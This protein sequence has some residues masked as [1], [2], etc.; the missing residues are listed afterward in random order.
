MS[1]NIGSYNSRRHR[2]RKAVCQNLQTNEVECATDG[3]Q[4]ETAQCMSRD[5]KDSST[6]PPSICNEVAKTAG[7]EVTN[8]A[9][10]SCNMGE[11]LLSEDDDT[12]DDD[13]ITAQIAQINSRRMVVDYSSDDDSLDEGSVNNQFRTH[14]RLDITD[15][16]A[17]HDSHYGQP[18]Q[19]QDFEYN[20]YTSSDNDNSSSD[21][22]ESK[23]SDSDLSTSS[24]SSSSLSVGSSEQS[25]SDTFSVD[26]HSTEQD[27]RPTS[28]VFHRFGMA[29]NLYKLCIEDHLAGP[30][31]KPNYAYGRRSRAVRQC[32]NCQR[33]GDSVLC[34]PSAV[35]VSVTEL[36]TY[37]MMHMIRVPADDL[38][39]KQCAFVNIRASDST[40]WVTL[41]WQCYNVATKQAHE[42]RRK[43]PVNKRLYGWPSFVFSMIMDQSI[44]GESRTMLWGVLPSRFRCWWVKAVEDNWN[45]SFNVEDPVSLVQDV[46]AAQYIWEDQLKN[47]RA[48]SLFKTHDLYCALPFVKCPWGCSEFLNRCNTIPFD[49]IYT[50]FLEEFTATSF[51]TYCSHQKHF[52]S[53]KDSCRKDFLLS[54][55]FILHNPKWLCS[56]RLCFDINHGPVFLC[57]RFHSASTTKRYIH[58]APSPTGCV[59]TR[60]DNQ[61]ALAVAK[62]RVASA[63]KKKTY[64]NSFQTTVINSRYDGTNTFVVG[65]FGK[66]ELCSAVSS[67]R[68]V[69]NIVL[70]PDVRQNI[71]DLCALQKLP[72]PMVQNMMRDA[73]SYWT[74]DK[75]VTCNS[76]QWGSTFIDAEA[77]M[78]LQRMLRQETETAVWLESGKR[79]WF[80]PSW[81]SSLIFVH[82]TD[83]FGGGF[84]DLPHMRNKAHGSLHDLRIVWV[85]FAL[86]TSSDKV[87]TSVVNSLNSVEQWQGWFLQLCAQ[88]CG[89]NLTRKGSSNNPFS[90]LKMGVAYG[91]L[92]EYEKLAAF[93]M[94]LYHWPAPYQ[95]S[96][97]HLQLM[98]EGIPSVCVVQW[99]TF[100]EAGGWEVL[101]EFV[102]ADT[103]ALLFVRDIGS[104]LE[105][106]VEISVGSW[107]IQN[108]VETVPEG[109]SFRATSYNSH[110]SSLQ[111]QWWKR[112]HY[113][114]NNW[115]KHRAVKS[116]GTSMPNCLP[117]NWD[118]MLYVNTGATP[119][120]DNRIH[121]MNCLG[122][123]TRLQCGIH[124]M[125]LAPMSVNQKQKCTFCDKNAI[126]LCCTTSS[127]NIGV[128]RLH[129]TEL[130]A[131]DNDPVL[132]HSPL[133]PSINPA[134]H[135]S[136][137]TETPTGN[138]DID[139]SEAQDLSESD[140]DSSVTFLDYPACNNENA[141]S[142]CSSSVA[143]AGD[144]VDDIAYNTIVVEDQMDED[145]V[146]D[147]ANQCFETTHAGYPDFHHEWTA[148]D[149]VPS[150]VIF[151]RYGR[152]L[153]R[154][155][156]KLTM[157]RKHTHWLQSIIS[158]G[159]RKSVPLLY[160]EGTIFP[161]LF[162]Y[163][164]TDGS[165]PG[166]L[167]TAF[168]ND[169]ATL[170]KMNVAT[171]HDHARTRIMDCSLLASTDISYCLY[172]FDA[173]MN[174]GS[175]GTDT[176][177]HMQRGWDAMLT[178]GEGV[179]LDNDETN[180]SATQL[181]FEPEQLENTI[182]CVKLSAA[183]ARFMA[184]YFVTFT[185]N[186][187]DNFGMRLLKNWLDDPKCTEFLEEQVLHS[188]LMS[189]GWTVNDLQ[190][191]TL[192]AD[193]IASSAVLAQRMYE[194]VWHVFREYFTN[195]PERP[196][197]GTV[198][199]IFDR[200]ENQDQMKAGNLP[201]KHMIVWIKGHDHSP[202]SRQKMVENIR[203]SIMHL[204]DEN[205]IQ[206]L[207]DQKIISSY[208]DMMGTMAKLG[209][210]LSHQHNVRCIVPFG[211]DAKET[212]RFLNWDVDGSLPAGFR[213]KVPDNHFL[214]ENPNEHCF[215]SVQ[216]EH[217]ESAKTVLREL[218]LLCE[219]ENEF[220]NVTEVYENQDDVVIH[221]PRTTA[222]HASF[223]P[224]FQKLAL[225]NPCNANVRYLNDLQASNYVSKYTVKV[226]EANRVFMNVPTLNNP[227]K[228]SFTPENL[229]NTKITSVR[230]HV[231]QNT[232]RNRQNVARI[233]GTP[234]IVML[235]LNQP[236]VYTT[237]TFAH[238]ATVP[239]EE[240]V[241]F[242]R[243]APLKK[244]ITEGRAPKQANSPDDLDTNQVV[245]SHIARLHW[246]PECRP[247]HRWS[248]LQAKDFCFCPLSIDTVTAFSLRP[249][250]LYFIRHQTVYLELFSRKKINVKKETGKSLFQCSVDYCSE[251]LQPSFQDCAWIDAVFSRIYI[252]GVGLP[253]LL[254]YVNTLDPADFEHVGMD[255]AET[256]IKDI[257][258]FLHDSYQQEKQGVI[259]T[260]ETKKRWEACKEM[261]LDP[262]DPRDTP[263]VYFTIVKPKL[264]NRFLVH[265]LLSMGKFTS[266]LELTLSGSI[267]NAFI[268]AKLLDPAHPQ[269]S[270]KSITKQY[271]LKQIPAHCS[272]VK[273]AD[274]TLVRAY[275]VLCHALLEDRD[276]LNGVP[277][278]G[279]PYP[280]VLYTRLKQ[281]CSEEV[282]LFCTEQRTLLTGFLI[283]ELTA[284]GIDGLP[285]V[286]T[287]L[288]CRIQMVDHPVWTSTN[289]IRTSAQ[290]EQSFT[291][292]QKVRTVARKK[293]RS[294]VLEC[295][296]THPKCLCT[297]GG[298]GCG[299][300]AINLI[301]LL[302]ALCMGLHVAT[303][304]LLSERANELGGMH[305]HRLFCLPHRI[306][307][308]MGP[309]Q[310]A[311]ASIANLYS[312]GTKQLHYLK[313]L[314]LLF[315]DELGQFPAKFIAVLDII[316]RHVRKSTLFL[317]GMLVFATYDIYQLLP[318]NEIPPLLSGHM[319]TSFSF[320]ELNHSVRAANDPVLRQLQHLTRIPPCD[321]TDEQL[322]RIREI[323]TTQCTFVP[324]LNHRSIP[325]NAMFVFGKKEPGRQRRD[326]KL[327][328]LEQTREI[329]CRVAV[330]SESTYQGD[331]KDAS[332][333]TI[334]LLDSKAKEDRKLYFPRD[335]VYQTTEVRGNKYNSNQL[336]VLWDIPSQED[337][338]K[339]KPVSFLVSPPGTKE[340]PDISQLHS[341]Q[342][343]LNAGWKLTTIECTRGSS[344]TLKNRLRGRRKQY[345]LRLHVTTTL[346]G[347]MGSTFAVLCSK[348]DK[349]PR[350]PYALW[351]RAQAIVLLSR[352]KKAKDIIF[353]GDPDLTADAIVDV[354]TQT[355]Q[356][357]DYMRHVLKAFLASSSEERQHDPPIIN[358]ASHP[359]RPID[360][361]L[362][363]DTTGYCYMI[364]SLQQPDVTY[365]GETSNLGRR[366]DQHN[367]GSGAIQ[368]ASLHLRKWILVCFV[369]GFGNN[370]VARKAFEKQWQH[371]REQ[372]RRLLGRH[373]TTDDLITIGSN[374]A[375]AHDEELTFVLCSTRQRDR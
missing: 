2:K 272:P 182:L 234:E 16:L 150:Q 221:V 83:E 167:P 91:N 282:Q 74:R 24:S 29:Q 209:T 137:L 38:R 199:H 41:C 240:R 298:P 194:N 162:W 1:C 340:I 7:M 350:S 275:E 105:T 370:K 53:L 5:A 99:D 294:L 84:E 26:N 174:L 11:S 233:I 62:P 35:G 130:S 20:Q 238:A 205:E 371:N 54:G 226:D 189:L 52:K 297:V 266:E 75:V 306:P 310:I 325:S 90:G 236:S 339:F 117:T 283:R 185:M 188:H 163:Q 277:S 200:S 220:G 128:C 322:L 160:P 299:K 351:E 192:H 140:D 235:L 107:H 337:I 10:H 374:L 363:T 331:W 279:D 73:K 320:L 166:A 286:E 256:K 343:L 103:R 366:I 108:V 373:L 65:R 230:Q 145:S 61:F 109:S 326:V 318:I 349:D 79:C 263:V 249:P 159:G 56:P 324:D 232:K 357:F 57:C 9:R 127:C 151:N 328:A 267:K 98:F 227:A 76:L 68:D 246:T 271:L 34:S 217:T 118:V 138:M 147:E 302:E 164:R 119:Y 179:K 193:M 347:A 253:K 72:K 197:G 121:Y 289:I 280:P 4:G 259:F 144:N 176:R 49:I 120:H 292:Q 143:G 300:T 124:H 251:K 323:I 86:L 247:F 216:K 181:I 191:E 131:S 274:E 88:K 362:P 15:H 204:V 94:E 314:D 39:P 265:I 206:D 63:V 225:L 152:L 311:R 304:A 316:L 342:S 132:V 149:N 355:T 80:K 288:A 208:D 295:H 19:P 31:Y 278:M 296:I 122:L 258:N 37:M 210:F 333:A 135:G 222:E 319:M 66:Y 262:E 359:F 134:E 67:L 156:N 13:T 239:M 93:V 102:T 96:P 170:A 223:S 139:L 8:D 372:R 64:S 146:A 224:V 111:N 172:S 255:N 303:T 218:G 229:P 123:Q 101:E 51:G 136:R 248:L 77:A 346:H 168:L 173:C 95:Y 330:D 203:G 23:Q 40:P 58:M 43:K 112:C 198:E 276:A 48:H 243:P 254:D 369:A 348:V 317:G 211:T 201:H 69:Y 245:L 237:F 184:T 301:C 290:C 169:N 281:K 231:D 261:F 6:A 344:H 116:F 285:S 345:A 252:R 293:L 110:W 50:N 44:T 82:S 241:A 92:N 364:S 214:T 361:E 177:I 87:W 365:I 367:S 215:I 202:E 133:L 190:Q 18:R 3:N 186:Q 334:S 270:V 360:V 356:Y 114:A 312:W 30:T 195:S 100:L 308:S 187:K 47:L 155:D 178:K 264:A 113:T 33:K 125:P 291:E 327:N 25:N 81:G 273:V 228:C 180:A 213:C 332:A 104:N 250:E 321:Y 268:A 341:A 284:M 12:G 32:Q 97:L 269:Q 42:R 161:S 309:G 148:N 165:I 27:Q 307:S 21:S 375:A 257:C 45:V 154:K 336:C 55:H 338:D 212:R 70:R 183:M 358:L 352:T 353:A 244:L 17:T 14:Q 78:H 175:R 287:V 129:R 28:A 46:S 368:T 85:T 315:I 106:D 329:P 171:L 207:L 196:M 354:L 126:L 157:S 313:Q 335:L 22:E 153:I 158:N 60:S 59:S 141:L 115:R 305:L 71:R 36:D 260:G 242:D 219:E 142:D 89:R